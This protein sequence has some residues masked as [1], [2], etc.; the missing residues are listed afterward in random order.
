MLD[1]ISTLVRANLN[2]LL[3]R[4]EDPEKVIKQVLVDMENQLIQVK[5]QVAASIADEKRLQTKF[6]E[7]QEQADEWQRKAELAVDRGQDEL[8]R[9]ALN[10][11]KN[12]AVAAEG[13]REQSEAQ[14]AQVASLR[15]GL[16]QLESKIEEA[17][18]KRDLLIARARRAKAEETMHKTLGSLSNSSA[19]SEFER[20]QSR[21]EEREARAAAYS[22]LSRDTLDDKFAALE[23]ESEV[24]RELAALKAR[25]AQT[26]LPSG[27]S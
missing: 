10:R 21:V 8:A 9:E 16:R 6:R 23:S 22:E 4:A 7:S 5:T 25:R 20:L 2:D 11:R 27:S 12:H 1:R 19:T 17:K 3:D 26:Q 15:D 13:L 18:S 24:D 14:S